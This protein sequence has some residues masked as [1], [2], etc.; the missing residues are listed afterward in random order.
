MVKKIVTKK[1]ILDGL[2]K[3]QQLPVKNYKGPQFI[4]AGPGAGKVLPL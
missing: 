3:D 2:N 4:I 1:S